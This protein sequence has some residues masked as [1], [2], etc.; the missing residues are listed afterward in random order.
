MR[1]VLVFGVLVVALLAPVAVE[2]Q[3][4]GGMASGA[5]PVAG[6]PMVEAPTNAREGRGGGFIDFGARLRARP[7]NNPYSCGSSGFN[8]CSFES[9]NFNTG[10]QTGVPAGRGR[11]TR[12][13]IRVGNV[14]GPFRVEVVETLRHVSNPGVLICCKLLRRSPILRPNRNAITTFQVNL[15]THTTRGP[16]A[17]G[18]YVG[19]RLELT[20]LS[21]NVPIPASN[22]PNATFTGWYPGWSFAGQERTGP[23]GGAGFTILLRARWRPA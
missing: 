9:I 23:L 1:R 17:F 3:P 18:Y 5:S 12:V 2:A 19:H 14:T 7:A 4:D 15:P 16:N 21:R 22:D 6:P 8:T 11:I 20:S 10:E 13:S